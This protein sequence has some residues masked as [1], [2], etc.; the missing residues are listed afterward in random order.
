MARKKEVEGEEVV[1]E[2]AR[3]DLRLDP[4]LHGLLKEAAQKV[5]VSVNQLVQGILWANV[6]KM[7]PGDCSIYNGVVSQVPFP[8]RAFFGELATIGEELPADVY[9]EFMEDF[10]RDIEERGLIQIEH[11]QKLGLVWYQLDFT[12]RGAVRDVKPQFNLPPDE[13]RI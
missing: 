1:V 2:R 8:G 13:E 4:E 5:G 11:L 3:M 9:S 6:R 10:S 7:I 12:E